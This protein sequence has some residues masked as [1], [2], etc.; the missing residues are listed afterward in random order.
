MVRSAETVEALGGV[1]ADP[2][3]A[4]GAPVQP[5]MP[6]APRVP[7]AL[8]LTSAKRRQ[9]PREMRRPCRFRGFFMLAVLASTGP[10]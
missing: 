2:L 8:A 9:A 1:A 10:G 7:S 6:A 3:G 4:S 5:P